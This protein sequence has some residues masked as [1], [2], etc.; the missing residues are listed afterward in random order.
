MFKFNGYLNLLY[1][2]IKFF[3]IFFKLGK[4]IFLGV[5]VGKFEREFF[6][7]IFIGVVNIF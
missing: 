3:I 5:R 4:L 6:K 1:V 2:L 7:N